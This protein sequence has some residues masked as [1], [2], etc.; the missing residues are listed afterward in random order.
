MFFPLLC[1]NELDCIL[2]LVKSE[3][4]KLSDI[5]EL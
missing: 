5:Y 1:F 4:I 2:N 3:T